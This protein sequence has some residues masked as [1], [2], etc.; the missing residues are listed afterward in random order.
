MPRFR[1][2]AWRPVRAGM[3]VAMGLSALFPVLDGLFTY[4]SQQM[5][6]QIGLFWLVLQGAL[7]IIGAGL[8]AVS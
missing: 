7:Y 3:F 4:G 6:Q 8:Y 2:P 5:Q 1:T